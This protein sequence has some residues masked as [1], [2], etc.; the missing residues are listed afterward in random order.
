[1]AEKITYGIKNV[2]AAKKTVSDLGVVTFGT[3]TALPGA[4]EISLPPV[5][6]NKKV[7]A[8]N[9]VYT[10]VAT[11][12]GYDGNLSIYNIPDWFS[13]EYLGMTVDDNGVLIENASGTKSDF[14]LIFEFAT[15][16][17]ST[18]R[19][20]MYNC[21]AGR[22]DLNGAT[23]EDTVDPQ[24]FSVPIVTS[25]LEGTEYVKASKVGDSTDATWASW[26]SSVYVPAATAQFK[27]T[28]VV[29]D[30]IG[31]LVVCGGKFAH[32]NASGNAYFMLP[33]GTYDIMVSATDK[34]AQVST[35]TVA[36][37]DV[38][39]TITLVDA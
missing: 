26:L 2:F 28:V 24:A 6:E 5:G 14:A 29:T 34:V 17:A 30:V 11:N 13:T 10:T 21:T 18:K 31:A 12:Q 9:V 3:P 38:S 20:V 37:A 16:T 25:P 22:T 7:Y 27:V 39:E 33:A 35:V 8:D 23:K 36:S 4:T 32:T 19:N 15:D 1:M